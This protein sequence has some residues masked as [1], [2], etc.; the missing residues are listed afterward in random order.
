M[1]S[2]KSEQEKT[3]LSFGTEKYLQERDE[4]DMKSPLKW[5][6]FKQHAD[7][8]GQYKTKEHQK[9]WR[10][11]DELYD[12]TKFDHPGG[13]DFIEFSTDTDITELFESSHPNIE[14]V[15][16]YLSKYRVEVPEKLHPRFT[17]NFTFEKDGFYSTLRQ[18]V[19]EGM[20]DLP[21]VPYFQTTAFVHDALLLGFLTFTILSISPWCQEGYLSYFLA[22]IGGSLLACLANT[23]HNFWHLKDTWR[24]FTFDLCLFSS[25]EWR[26][27]HAYSH[28]TFPNTILDVEIW[29]FEPYL[30]FLPLD[31]KKNIFTVLKTI[32]VLIF[33]FPLVCMISVC[34]M[35]FF[36][37]VYSNAVPSFS[38]LPQ[39]LIRTVK[40]LIGQIKKRWE[41]FLP[42]YFFFSL[43]YIRG[44]L[45]KT[46]VHHSDAAITVTSTIVR[47]KLSFI[48]LRVSH[49]ISLLN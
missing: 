29:S 32:L 7:S 6:E 13:F 34:L 22:A 19:F 35:F 47:L 25:Y 21:S 48:L 40:M 27:S 45:L 2:K 9:L 14:K 8:L 23:S 31:K 20:K 24:V 12:L 36:V 44:F 43:V 5:L 3:L 17:G 28:H 26:I 16:G 37:F 46:F 15:R 33:F 4:L 49:L 41:Y 1:F 30:E 39:T 10:I 18:R 38:F 11:H 42:F